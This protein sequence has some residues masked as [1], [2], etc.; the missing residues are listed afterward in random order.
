MR[1]FVSIRIRLI[2]LLCVQH[3]VYK[4]YISQKTPIGVSNAHKHL[5]GAFECRGDK[6]SSAVSRRDLWK[7]THVFSTSG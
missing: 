3:A 7:L 6:V 4:L 2:V 1:S 5:G